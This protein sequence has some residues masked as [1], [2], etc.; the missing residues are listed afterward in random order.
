V[1]V[2]GKGMN[3]EQDALELFLVML[4]LYT[5][6]RVLVYARIFFKFYVCVHSYM[7]ELNKMLSYLISSV[8]FLLYL[9]LNDFISI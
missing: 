3:W 6:T 5:L 7:L 9:F 1:P 4:V 2:A 8:L